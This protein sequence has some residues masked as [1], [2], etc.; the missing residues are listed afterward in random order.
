MSRFWDIQ[1]DKS[2]R[3]LI[4]DEALKL[5]KLVANNFAEKVIDPRYITKK[6]NQQELDVLVALRYNVGSLR[7]ID[8]LIND[9]NKNSSYDII[10]EDIDTYISLSE[11]DFVI[12]NGGNKLGLNQNIGQ[13]YN[14][15]KI[16]S[17]SEPKQN[18][19]N[20]IYI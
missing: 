18:F 7:V 19:S 9:I 17:I 8:N 11:R 3:D 12:N 16:L 6:L 14:L 5:L 13:T 4:S 20:Y 2:V 15:G 1:E 10:K